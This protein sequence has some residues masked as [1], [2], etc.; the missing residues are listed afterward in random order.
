MLTISLLSSLFTKG[1]HDIQNVVIH[2]F[3]SEVR[4]TGDFIDGSMA[5]GLLIVGYSLTDDSDVYYIYKD[6]EQNIVA[7]LT[8]LTGSQYGVSVF[9][10]EENRLPFSRVATTPSL[11]DNSAQQGLYGVC[12]VLHT[13]QHIH[14]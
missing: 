2:S 5:T 7:S 11:V 8:G 9:V 6:Y 13:L 1:T 14:M 10:V 4:V 3:N 12:V